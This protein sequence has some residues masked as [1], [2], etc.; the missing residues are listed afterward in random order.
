MKHYTA[1]EINGYYAHDVNVTVSARLARMPY[2]QA[3]IRIDNAR[4]TITPD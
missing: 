4:H 1:H 2:A 3:G